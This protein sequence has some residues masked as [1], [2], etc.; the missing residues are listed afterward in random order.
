MSNAR[1]NAVT[2]P[3]QPFRAIC[4]FTVAWERPDQFR[5]VLSQIGS[6]TNIRG[7]NAYPSLI[8][9]TERKP[10]RVYLEDSSNDVDNQFGGWPW[11][12][13]DPGGSAR[14]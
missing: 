6:F 4:A 7:G 8:R 2:A 1:K 5:K 14:A 11:P 3:S 10:L 12:A 13:D 9:K